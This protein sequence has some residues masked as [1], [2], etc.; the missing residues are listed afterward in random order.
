MKKFRTALCLAVIA[1][2]LPGIYFAAKRLPQNNSALIGKKYAGWSG[3]LR[4]WA[5]EGWTG[6]DLMAGWIGRCAAAFEKSH[7]GVYIEVKYVSAE[8]AQLRGESGVRPPDMILF[9]PGLLTSTS[10]LAALDVLPVRADLLGCGQGFAAPVALGGYVW[11]VN[12]A[13]EG[14]AVPADEPWRQWSRAAAE[15]PARWEEIELEPPGVDLGLPASADAAEPL[16]RFL[17]GELGAVCVTQR[18]L[19]RLTRMSDQGRGPEWTLAP[20]ANWTDQALYLSVPASGDERES[21]SMEFL[22]HLLTPECQAEL[23]RANLF[24]VLDAPTGY[25]GGSAM[26][27]LDAALLRPGLTVSPAF[28]IFPEP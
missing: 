6:G 18:E 25:P 2:C 21:L 12:D 27:I 24:T 23:T 17:N 7:P 22:A 13:A 10:G 14:T 4:I 16:A 1:L 28:N 11:A 20:A 19:A 3:V 15:G 5:F 26:E 9:P 8:Q